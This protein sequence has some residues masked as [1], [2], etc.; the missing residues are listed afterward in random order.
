VHNTLITASARL[1]L[2][3]TKSSAS[4]FWECYRFQATTVHIH[5]TW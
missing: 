5:K 2:M 4:L 3:S 1:V